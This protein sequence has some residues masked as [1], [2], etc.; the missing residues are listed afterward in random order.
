MELFCLPIA[1][2]SLQGNKQSVCMDQFLDYK[3]Q[4]DSEKQQ[5]PK[6]MGQRGRRENQGGLGQIILQETR[7]S[8]KFQ[9]TNSPKMTHKHTSAQSECHKNTDRA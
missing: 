5:S 4:A 2:Q 3:E 1:C 6:K 7:L 8:H 9:K